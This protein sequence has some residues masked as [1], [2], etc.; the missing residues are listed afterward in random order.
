MSDEFIS[1]LK[2][3]LS[4]SGNN[5]ITPEKKDISF[6]SIEVNSIVD[7]DVN[8]LFTQPESPI[9]QMFSNEED[10]ETMKNI[11]SS[12]DSDGDGKLNQS[13]LDYLIYETYDNDNE[14]DEEVITADDINEFLK[15]ADKIDR[16][17]E[18]Y[19][20][21]YTAEEL[22]ANAYKI[23]YELNADISVDEL[24]DPNSD[25][26]QFV[27]KY[28]TN[29]VFNKGHNILAWDYADDGNVFDLIDILCCYNSEPYQK[30]KDGMQELKA[31]N[32]FAGAQ[33]FD[34]SQSY[35]YKINSQPNDMCTD[36]ICFFYDFSN[37]DR[38]WGYREV[39]TGEN[40]LLAD[41]QDYYCE[42]DS[43]DDGNEILIVSYTDKEGKEVKI[44]TTFVGESEKISSQTQIIDGEE[45]KVEF[46]LE[47]GAYVVI[48][49]DKSVKTSEQIAL[50]RFND[51]ALD[52]SGGDENAIAF[53]QGLENASKYQDMYDTLMAFCS[54][55]K[56]TAEIL[57]AC[58]TLPYQS[59]GVTLDL[60]NPYNKSNSGSANI[61]STLFQLKDGN[62][63]VLN[64]AVLS[65]FN[66]FGV[67]AVRE[68]DS[69]FEINSYYINSTGEL[70]TRTSI[71]SESDIQMLNSSFTSQ[72]LIKNYGIMLVDG[73]VQ[74]I[75][76]NT[77]RVPGEGQPM[78][79]NPDLYTGL[80]EPQ[81]TA[82]SL[83][84]FTLMAEND[85]NLTMVLEEL[86]NNVGSS[87]YLSQTIQYKDSNGSISH[88]QDIKL[89]LDENNNLA[90]NVSYLDSDGNVINSLTMSS[91]EYL[92]RQKLEPIALKYTDKVGLTIEKLEQYQ[93]IDIVNNLSGEMLLGLYRQDEIDGWCGDLNNFFK[94]IINND[95]ARSEIHGD[96][97]ASFANNNK[98]IEALN[99][100]G[101][102]EFNRVYSEIYGRDYNYDQQIDTYD[103]IFNVGKEMEQLVCD[104]QNG[105]EFDEEKYQE[106]EEQY[107]QEYSKIVG[108]SE[109]ETKNILYEYAKDQ[110]NAVERCKAIVTTAS[111]MAAVLIAPMTG[112][113]SLLGF[114]AIGA[115]SRMFVGATN[116]WSAG[117]NYSGS[118]A[119]YDGIM[120]GTQ[121]FAFGV[122]NKATPYIAKGLQRVF[123]KTVL[124][125]TV[126]S[127]TN[128]RFVV[129][130]TSNGLNFV[131]DL[132][133][134]QHMVVMGNAQRYLA[135]DT[136]LFMTGYNVLQ[137]LFTMS[138]TS[139]INGGIYAGINTSGF[140][141]AEAL[142]GRVYSLP[143]VLNTLSENID[144]GQAYGFRN[145]LTYAGLAHIPMFMNYAKSSGLEISLGNYGQYPNFMNQQ[146]STGLIVQNGNNAIATVGQNALMYPGA[147]PTAMIPLT[148]QA[149]L[150][151]IPLLA[152]GVTPLALPPGASVPLLTAGTEV[153]TL[154]M[155]EQN[156]SYADMTIFEIAEIKFGIENCESYNELVQTLRK[157]RYIAKKDIKLLENV[158]NA[159]RQ[160]IALK[161]M[162]MSDFEIDTHNAIELSKQGPEVVES[163]ARVL[164][165]KLMSLENINMFSR[166]I[167]RIEDIGA[168]E[169]TVATLK[170][171]SNSTESEVVACFEKF[172]KQQQLANVKF[173]MIDFANYIKIFDFASL[174][175]DFPLFNEYS[176]EN[177]L[178]LLNYHVGSKKL[179]FTESDLDIP[180]TEYLRQNFLDADKLSALLDVFPLSNR[181]VGEIPN[182][183]LSANSNSNKQMNQIDGAV[184][185]F[186]ATGDIG[187][188]AS[189]LKSI[190]GQEV[191]VSEIGSGKLGTAYKISVEGAEDV[192]LKLFFKDPKM[193]VDPNVHGGRVEPQTAMFAN[194]HS[195]D[196]V[197]MYMGRVASENEPVSYMFTQFLGDG[198]AITSTNPLEVGRYAFKPI[199]DHPGN[200]YQTSDGRKIFFDF[201]AINI[202]IIDSEDTRKR[203][204]IHFIE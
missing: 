33:G 27:K 85:E 97:F 75:E 99:N 13:E 138:G 158:Y 57:F 46:D 29:F 65:A 202:D 146:V 139:S 140:F 105:A 193:N 120:G 42:Y 125:Q 190:L 2:K 180:L 76:Y 32:V 110:N 188:F 132:L 20:D 104:Y 90:L 55:D 157:N 100:G 5:P 171:N 43:D 51:L 161:L 102:T 200:Y 147:L 124:G 21:E 4:L 115:G 178:N 84:D 11:F 204:H 91:E 112:G 196:F 182:G 162:L 19:G 1:P 79:I 38:P 169:T 187:K 70:C 101:S 134:N 195:N 163:I 8:E 25:F 61:L 116:S 126:L 133:T 173:D 189:G 154:P 83:A 167:G 114:A 122:C 172:L 165:N 73:N 152:Q 40:G 52:L 14:N 89:V 3:F 118:E 98:L 109:E 10:V 185:E 199:D 64:D 15:D 164:D 96:I 130:T 63:F 54:N 153:T 7:R 47:T 77:P 95:L 30:Y 82:Y 151:N 121:G 67:N 36:L 17:Q 143:T 119:L 149:S 68:I 175:R 78:V 181:I 186:I 58:L 12:L 71:N 127:Q 103:T 39:I 23:A 111:L 160:E 37:V 94:E 136:R 184:T 183:W 150:A 41:A 168:I 59:D 198:V 16:L 166:Y 148:T 92:Q 113:T 141:L 170:A 44:S 159:E 192:C 117:R 88:Q 203:K 129:N 31:L 62:K 45:T 6:E 24:I 56:N 137:N 87:D 145:G 34:V 123:G 201:G 155:S 9:F 194:A 128:G 179:V 108:L 86:K 176:A 131:D 53:V 106:L 18:E 174:K 49:P 156:A 93:F 60:P 35:L 81:V 66:N 135:M 69:G 28:S 107:I 144:M 80:G 22:V 50:D 142:Q 197:K 48:Y 26:N 74:I 177:W 191:T 72:G